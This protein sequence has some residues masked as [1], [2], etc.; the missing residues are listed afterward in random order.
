[1]TLQVGRK[2]EQKIIK[3]PEAKKDGTTGPSAL[4]SV[5]D[6]AK[7][8]VPAVTDKDAKAADPTGPAQVIEP[9]TETIP[10]GPVYAFIRHSDAGAVING[11]MEKRAF[12]VYESVLTGLPQNR[13]E[14]FEPVPAPAPAATPAPA[15]K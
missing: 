3:A 6:L 7:A 5:A 12:Q 14:L 2:P 10:A 13:S 4:G 15:G 8:A 1:M 11:L 9:A